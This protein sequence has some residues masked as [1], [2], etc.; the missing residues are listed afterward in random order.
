[1][2]FKKFLTSTTLLTFAI[3]A[4]SLPAA[5]Q[6]SASPFDGVTIINDCDVECDLPSFS[7]AAELVAFMSEATQPGGPARAGA[8]GSP[9]G[10]NGPAGIGLGLGLGLNSPQT[11]F[12]S[13]ETGDPTFSGTLFGVPFTLPDHVSVSYTHLTLPTTPYV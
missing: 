13:F 8:G 12:V 4:F 10:A 6:N 5:A 9:E 3:S 11:V 7:S 2:N 1:M